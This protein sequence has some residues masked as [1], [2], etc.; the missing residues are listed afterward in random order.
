MPR[1]T[2]CILAIIMPFLFFT[3]KSEAKNFA[4]FFG[5]EPANTP[6]QPGFY[7]AALEFEKAISRS[8][9]N[10]EVHLHFNGTPEQTNQLFNETLTYKLQLEYF[11][12]SFTYANSY[13]NE[14]LFLKDL[15]DGKKLSPND[16]ILIFFAT[17]GADQTEQ[18]KALNQVTHSIQA[19][20]QIDTFINLDGMKSLLASIPKFVQIAVIDYSC[21]S[22]YSLHMAAENICVVSASKKESYSYVDFYSHLLTKFQPN[23]NLENIFLEAQ[24]TNQGRS[25]PQ[26]STAINDQIEI[27]LSNP[28]LLT[29]AGQNIPELKGLTESLI[30][31]Q[32]Q[33]KLQTNENA[34]TQFSIQIE[35]LENKIYSIL[36][37]NF[38]SELKNQACQEFRF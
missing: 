21:Y 17:H 18:S 29:N 25:R 5:G 19:G 27:T 7:N 10:W 14:K 37:N 8:Q 33:L 4:F 26:I 38:S 32:Q 24:K 2:L 11:T 3:A 31:A 13:S 1:L 35:K 9:E 16:K 12:N 23:Q 15:V 22:G 34:K 28:A 30:I 36:Y 6:A 20:S